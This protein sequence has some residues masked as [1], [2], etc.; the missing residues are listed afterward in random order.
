MTIP[1]FIKYAKDRKQRKFRKIQQAFKAYCAVVDA[2]RY[3]MTPIPKF[4][5]GAAQGG[6]AIVG[7]DF[8]SE[9]SRSEM[10]I[11]KEGKI[12]NYGGR[13][14]GKTFFHKNWAAAVGAT[15]IHPKDFK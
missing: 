14:L 7:M 12:I 3:L 6:Q 1:R 13:T 10:V 15:T 9:P 11:M 2:A 5:P 4:K 8:S